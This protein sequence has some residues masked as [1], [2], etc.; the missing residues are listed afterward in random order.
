MCLT[1]DEEL[2]KEWKNRSERFFIVYKV[3]TTKEGKI[4]SPWQG[5]PINI[6]WYKGKGKPKISNDR[7]DG[8]NT[9]GSGYIHAYTNIKKAIDNRI[10]HG[11]IIVKCKGLKKDLVAMG[12]REDIAFTKIWISDI[13]LERAKNESFTLE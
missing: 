9:Y 4:I 7:Q 5:F 11:D 13:E 10:C 8:I 6:G 3:F 12:T 1:V 2:T